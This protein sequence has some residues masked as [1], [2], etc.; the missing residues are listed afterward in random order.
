MNNQNN[1]NKHKLASFC[2]VSLYVQIDFFI[3]YKTNPKLSIFKYD[4]KFSLKIKHQLLHIYDNDN[5][6][7]KHNHGEA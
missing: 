7:K 1:V 3:T 5:E 2:D 4:I 6:E